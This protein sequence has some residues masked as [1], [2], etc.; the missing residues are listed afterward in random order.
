MIAINAP[1]DGSGIAMPIYYHSTKAFSSVRWQRIDNAM[2]QP[3]RSIL[4]VAVITFA[5][6]ILMPPSP[7]EEEALA[8]L[9][10]GNSYFPWFLAFAALVGMPLAFAVP[11][12][13][14]SFMGRSWKVPSTA[15]V[16]PRAILRLLAGMIAGQAIAT[17][18]LA[19][20]RDQRLLWLLPLHFL[21]GGAFC[22]GAWRRLRKPASTEFTMR[23]WP[24]L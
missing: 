5:V 12:L 15:Y 23:W 21:V 14:A 19:L 3:N 6:L 2:E 13:R 10:S 9:V 24:P 8:I 20:W 1:V 4:V 16:I 18:T 17:L 22:L 11:S 7:A